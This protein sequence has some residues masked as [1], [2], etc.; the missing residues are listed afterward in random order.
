MSIH[1]LDN[2]TTDVPSCMTKTMSHGSLAFFSY[3]YPTKLVI[4]HPIEDAIESLSI[5]LTIVIA[6]FIPFLFELDFTSIYTNPF[7][8]NGSPQLNSTKFHTCSPCIFKKNLIDAS[9][10]DSWFPWKE[11][12]LFMHNPI[13]CFHDSRS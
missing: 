13:L 4:T 10:G 3:H 11:C 8:F 12:W 1:I 5:F 9:N 6:H 7:N 2:F